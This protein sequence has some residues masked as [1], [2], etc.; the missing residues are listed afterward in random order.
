MI[1]TL[2]L[3]AAFTGKAFGIYIRSQ[4]LG[5]PS[6]SSI[7][8]GVLSLEIWIPKRDHACLP[9]GFMF[10]RILRQVYSYNLIPWIDVSDHTKIKK[11][12][13]DCSF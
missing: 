10:S 5:I 7:V 11:L 6:A 8:R 9:F 3:S 4:A 2:L 1:T 12:V 13:M